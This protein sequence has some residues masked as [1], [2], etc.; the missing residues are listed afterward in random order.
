MLYLA[1]ICS[2]FGFTLQPY[3]QSG[4]TAER[5]SVLCALL[6][7]TVGVLGAVYLG[8]T[9]TVKGIIG[10]VLIIASIVV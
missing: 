5:A 4:T 8:E 2:V 1:I 10:A 6:P 7:F 9:L 3:D